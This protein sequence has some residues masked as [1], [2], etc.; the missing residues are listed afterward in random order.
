MVYRRATR[1]ALRRP[2]RPFRRLR[3]ARRAVRPRIGRNIAQPVQYFKRTA[4]LTNWLTND[5][6]IDKFKNFTVQLSD[7][8]GYNEFIQLYDQYKIAKVVV[9]LVPMF[10]TSEP[11]NASSSTVPPTWSI[12]DYDGGFP[13][14]RNAMLEYQNLRM[15]NGHK[16]HKRVFVPRMQATVY[17]GVTSA[18]VPR[19]G[20]IDCGSSGVPHYGATF[21]AL[22]IGGVDGPFSYDLKVTY[23]LAFKNVR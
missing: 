23:Y 17:N 15:V 11:L 10:N 4:Y 16:W 12:L 20:F 2:R 7:V 8:P 14:T 22:P 5:T 18:Y 1:P 21:M 9:S 3:R 6:I 13:A 19:T